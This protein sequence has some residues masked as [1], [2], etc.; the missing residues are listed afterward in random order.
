MLIYTLI[1]AYVKNMKDQETELHLKIT[2]DLLLFIYI[3][4]PGEKNIAPL[5]KYRS[6]YT[7]LN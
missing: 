7:E 6:I 5:L 4:A 2:R 3:R 1:N